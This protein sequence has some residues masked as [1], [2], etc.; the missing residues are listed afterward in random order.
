MEAKSA[1]LIFS[2]LFLM[3]AFAYGEDGDIDIDKIVAR[4]QAELNLTQAQTDSI[5]PIVEK[6]AVKHQDLRHDLKARMVTDSSVI[7]AKMEDLREEENRE[8]SGILTPQQLS[9][10]N[11]KQKR[12][13]LLNKD[14][15]ID[16][17]WTPKEGQ[18]GMGTSF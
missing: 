1:I 10:W 7:L 18:L 3:I 12:S 14:R 5:R 17:D 8:L 4:M 9:K 11:N 2:I 13:N 16:N 6:Y 15:V